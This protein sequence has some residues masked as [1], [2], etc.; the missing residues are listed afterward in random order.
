MLLWPLIYAHCRLARLRCC[1]H[2]LDDDEDSIYSKI[3][4]KDGP[5]K[6]QQLSEVSGFL[7]AQQ[8]ML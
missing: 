1:K 2:L 6:Y 7:N 5:F 4:C 8:I 3:L